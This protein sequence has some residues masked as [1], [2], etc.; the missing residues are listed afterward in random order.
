MGGQ[1]ANTRVSYV[2]AMRDQMRIYHNTSFAGS[3]LKDLGLARPASQDKDSAERFEAI[4]KE[5][6]QDL[7][8]DVIFVSAYGPGSPDTIASYR[9]DPLWSRLSAVQ[10]GKVFEVNDD[11]WA[12]GTGYGAANRIIDDL[13]KD[14]VN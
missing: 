4:S 11:I 13:F 12:V 3:V 6:F 2:R 9:N 7:D 14:L 8:G 10:K 5:R 1:P